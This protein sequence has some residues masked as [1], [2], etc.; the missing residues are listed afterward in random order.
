MPEI[1][2]SRP[3]FYIESRILLVR[4]QKVLLNGNLAELYGVETK[5][6]NQ[7]VKRNSTRF[8]RDFMFRLS[9]EEGRDLE[10]LRSQ[11]VTL[12]QGVHRKYAPYVFTEQGHRN[13]V[14]RP[15]KQTRH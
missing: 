13:V 4:G 11:S 9:L 2:G 7:A 3:E 5:V 14:F 6:L 12:K 15:A 10:S 1:A 8:P